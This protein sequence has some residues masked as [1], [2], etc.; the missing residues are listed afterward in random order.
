MKDIRQHF[1]EQGYVVIRGLLDHDRDLAAFITEYERLLERVA[2]VWLAEGSVRDDLG[3]LP[4]G[5]RF[6]RLTHEYGRAY[7]QLFDSCL[8]RDIATD[9]PIHLGDATF[10]LLINPR[11]LDAVEAL[12]GSEIYVNPMHHV[13]IKPPERW[14]RPHLRNGITAASI[15]HQDQAATLPEADETDIITVW[16]P[17]TDALEE[18]SCMMVVPGAHH[19]PMIHH[20]P[21]MWFPE[22]E[23]PGKPVTLPMRRGDVLFFHRRTPHASSPNVS[24]QVR[25]SFDVRYQPIDRPTGRPSFPGF[26]ARSR[27]HPER[28]CVDAGRWRQSWLDARARLAGKGPLTFYRSG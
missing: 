8:P 1:D 13:R 20:R 2:R 9:T 22:S 7:Y 11:L 23:L 18:Q 26:V 5:E 21:G 19:A 28:A 24:D 4:F 25:M 15:W 16:C 3:G 17:V 6:T 10:D 14:V 12:I 27:R